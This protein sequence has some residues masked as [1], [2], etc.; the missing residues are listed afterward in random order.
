MLDSF[1]RDILILLLII[2]IAIIFFKIAIDILFFVIGQL[3]AYA[4]YALCCILGYGYD[5][6]TKP[7]K[8]YK[9]IKGEITCALPESLRYFMY[10]R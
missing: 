8:T 6:I 2:S 7:K 10:S 3:G 5:F 4:L 9:D 1:G